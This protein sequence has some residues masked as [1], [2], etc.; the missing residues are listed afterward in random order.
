MTSRL[1]SERISS[2]GSSPDARG[3][4][5]NAAMNVLVVEDDPV[6]GKSLSKGLSE[7]GH[8][9]VWVKDGNNGLEKSLSQR[10]DAIVLD[11]LLPGMSGM[12]ALRQIRA[13]GVRTPILLLTA[14]GAVEERVTGLKAGA[15]DYMV[16]PFAFPE[17]MARLEAVCRRTV[18]RPAP[19]MTV[20]DIHLDLTSRRVQQ[21]EAEIDLTPTE[22]RILELL[23]RHAGQVVTRKMLCEDLWDTDWEG[24]TNVI[25]VHINRIRKKFDREGS[26]SSIIQTVRGR[27]Y[28]LR[29]S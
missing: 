4:E 7:A 17:L 16:K 2:A 18:D 29:A 15:D 3:E 27:G 9:C 20:G 28:A 24:T 6:I 21:G 23:M 25:E 11:L 26:S 13:A 5:T 8:N 10:F 22:F 14:L 1:S 12:E 19:I